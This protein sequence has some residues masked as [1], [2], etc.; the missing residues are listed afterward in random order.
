MIYSSKLY[1]SAVLILSAVPALAAPLGVAADYNVFV[2]GSINQANTDIEGRAAVGGSAQFSNFG[3]GTTLSPNSS[4]LDLIVGGSLTYINGQIHNGSGVY[5]G[6]GSISGVGVPNGTLTQAPSPI[7]FVAAGQALIA[8]SDGYAA[9]A[10]VAVAAQ[11]GGLNLVGTDANLNIFYVAAGTLASLNSLSISA[12]VGSTVLVNVAGATNSFTNAGMSVSGTNRQN[13]LFN[14]F[15]TTSL[16][17]S[18]MGFQGSILAPEAAFQF[19]NGQINGNI[20]VASMQ[21]GGESHNTLFTGQLPPW[22]PGTDVPEPA[23]WLCTGA[24]FALVALG[25]IRRRKNS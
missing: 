8:E 14:F 1:L 13:V 3:I 24:G 22:D 19:N 21:G 5:A 15:E 23:T 10:A 25:A 4:R 17:M 7:D 2:L 6:S 20:V 9:L 12:P 18:G 11:Y 16:T